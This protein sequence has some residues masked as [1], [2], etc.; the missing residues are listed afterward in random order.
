MA[1]WG[2]A[3]GLGLWQLSA[4][5]ARAEKDTYQPPRP[6]KKAW[7]WPFGDSSSAKKEEAEKK[8]KEEAAQKANAKEAARKLKD[9]IQ[10]PAPAV[11]TVQA[12]V[13]TSKEQAKFIRRQ[14]VCDRLREVAIETGNV[15]L[16]KQAQLLEQRAWLIYE[17]KTVQARLP[18]LSPLESTEAAKKLLTDEPIARRRTPDRPERHVRSIDARNGSE[19][20]KE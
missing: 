11:E 4:A 18:G 2:I 20:E 10:A 13:N 14:Q 1:L 17:Q 7:W 8:K 3:A 15:E 9:P 19:P 6:A 16:E 5:P 12:S